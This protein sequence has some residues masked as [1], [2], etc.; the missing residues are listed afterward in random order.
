MLLKNCQKLKNELAKAALKKNPEKRAVFVA[1]VVSKALKQVGEDPVLVGGSAVAF[2]TSAQYT[3]SDIDMVAFSSSE[4][5]QIMQELG[6]KHQGKDFVHQKLGLYVEFP[7]STLGPGERWVNLNIGKN[8]LRI[9][10][11]EDLI[12]DRLNHYKYFQSSVDAI[13]VMMLLELPDVNLKEVEKKAQ[14]EDTL[15]AL[16]YIDK[17]YKKIIRKKLS[18][19]K[20]TDLLKGFFKKKIL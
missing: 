10:S 11:V 9:I 18:K 4:V 20:A 17:A 15:D 13:N 6:F 2:Y 1:A 14:I 7:S 16:D 5:S 3:T 12:V 19:E 8:T